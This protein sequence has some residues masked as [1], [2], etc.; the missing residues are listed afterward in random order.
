MS[1]ETQCGLTRVFQ[2]CR[3][4]FARERFEPD[5]HSHSFH[6]TDRVLPLRQ[7]GVGRLVET[8]GSMK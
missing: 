7:D 3:F 6:A 4:M 8:S 1:A 5:Q 2:G